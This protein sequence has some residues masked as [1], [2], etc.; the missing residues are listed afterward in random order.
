MMSDK[1]ISVKEVSEIIGGIF[2]EYIDKFDKMSFSEIAI[3][4]NVLIKMQWAFDK[5][6]EELENE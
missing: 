1:Q 4:E 5:K 6:F 3:V 2:S